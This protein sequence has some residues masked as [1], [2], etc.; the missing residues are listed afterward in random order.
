MTRWDTRDDATAFREA[1]T[2]AASSLPGAAEVAVMPSATLGNNPDSI[3][4]LI[5]SDAATLARLRAAAIAAH[6]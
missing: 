2:V 3:A 5:A 1:A 6:F 4:V